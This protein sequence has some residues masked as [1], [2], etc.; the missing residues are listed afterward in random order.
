MEELLPRVE[1]PTLVV[2]GEHDA[3]SSQAWCE[4]AAELLPRGSLAV[5][6][7]AG[8]RGALSAPVRVAALVRSFLEEVEERVDE[9]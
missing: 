4:R 1:A 7:G 6:D 3:F 5:V 9:G 8:A 2:R